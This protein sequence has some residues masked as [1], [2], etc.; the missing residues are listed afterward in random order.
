MNAKVKLLVTAGMVSLVLASCSKDDGRSGYATDDL[1][2]FNTRVSRA[3]ETTLANLKDIK[4]Y[5]DAEGYPMF[6]D[7]MTA[8]KAEGKNTFEF[9]TPQYWPSGISTVRFWA[10]GPADISVKPHITADGQT[11]DTYTPKSGVDNPGKEH[12]DLIVAYT[13]ADRDSATGANV[14]L[15]FHHAMSQVVVNAK[16]GSTDGTREI[17]VAGAWIVNAKPSGVLSFDGT[18]EGNNHMKWNAS[19]DKTIYGLKLNTPTKLTPN[20]PTTLIGGSDNSSLMLIPQELDEWNLTEDKENAEAGAYILV[21]CRVELRHNGNIHSGTT[22]DDG[23]IHSEGDYHYHQAFPVSDTFNRNAYG[24]TCVPINTKWLPNKKYVYN[25]EFCG[26]KSGAGV[27]PPTLP[28]GLPEA[29]E[30]PSD[31]ETGDNVL[32]QPINFTVTISNWT[33]GVQDENVGMQ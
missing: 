6:I 22:T 12:E 30:K 28:E 11:F 27:Y 32:D 5:A 13:A 16:S 1:I 33:A 29:V 18:T 14:P 3:T 31:K 9:A 25:L 21:L 2:T 20:T 19:G 15:D 7:G 24:Y 4:V 23:P 17:T 10:Y 8:S 26:S